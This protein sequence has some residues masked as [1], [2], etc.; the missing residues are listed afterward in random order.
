MDENGYPFFGM[1][2]HMEPWE[3][4]KYKRYGGVVYIEADC[5]MYEYIFSSIDENEEWMQG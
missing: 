1:Y 3:Y 5:I 4:Q 2:E